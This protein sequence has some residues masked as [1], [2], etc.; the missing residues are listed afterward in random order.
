VLG[1]DSALLCGFDEDELNAGRA[2]ECTMRQKSPEH[3]AARRGAGLQT[4]D[5]YLVASPTN[6]RV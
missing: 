1:A 2:G 6:S 3:G 4:I 5:V